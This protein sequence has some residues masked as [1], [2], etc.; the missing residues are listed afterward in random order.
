M[1]ATAADLSALHAAAVAGDRVAMLLLADLAEGA[2]DDARAGAWRFLADP[3]ETGWERRAW[4]VLRSLGVPAGHWRGGHHV[5]VYGA[6]SLLMI[7][8]A[9][10]AS[11]GRTWAW[12][13]A[14]WTEGGLPRSAAPPRVREAVLAACRLA[15]AGLSP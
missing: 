5:S 12:V 7:T 11:W 6:G 15:L 14:G 3:P 2:R 8:R 9:P 4:E 13:P 10:V 1:T